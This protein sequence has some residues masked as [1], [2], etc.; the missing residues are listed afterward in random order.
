MTA[1]DTRVALEAGPAL[2]PSPQG[3]ASRRAPRPGPVPKHLQSNL[4]AYIMIAP[5]VVLLGIFVFWPLGYAFWLSGHSINFYLGNEWVGTQFYRYVLTDDGFWDA[6]KVGLTYAVMVVPTGIV[7]SLFLALFIKTLRGRTASVMKTVIYL[8][9]VLSSVIAAIIFAFMGQDQGLIN[10]AVGVVGIEPIAWLNSPDWALPVV[11]L[12]GVW[13]GLG[14]STLILL[15]ALLD[16]PESY[17]ES[18]A[19]DGA[20]FLQQTWYVTI[21]LLRNVFLYLLVTGFTLTIQEFQLPLIMTNGGPVGATKT[22]NLFIFDSFRENTPYSTSFSLAA[23]LLLFLVLGAISLVIFRL[24]R[25]E[26]AIDA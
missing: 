21:P 6:I 9:A 7:V 18:A 5:M 10:A 4:T 13:L 14:V 20:N 25:S 2:A 16:I 1:A 3:R 23:A 12:A 8:P 17:Y 15:S 22:P 24:L 26:K 19:L 11:A